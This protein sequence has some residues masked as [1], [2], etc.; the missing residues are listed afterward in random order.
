MECEG[1][2]QG[3]GFICWQVKLRDTSSAGYLA[4]YGSGRYERFVSWKRGRR[5]DVEGLRKKKKRG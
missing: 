2:R 5:T 3:S 4:A 1:R